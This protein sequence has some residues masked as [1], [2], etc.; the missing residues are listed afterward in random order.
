MFEEMGNAQVPDMADR[1]VPAQRHSAKHVRSMALPIFAYPKWAPTV[2][3]N[4]K[5]GFGAQKEENNTQ[6]AIKDNSCS[7]SQSS[8]KN[9]KG[10]ATRPRHRTSAL[11]RLRSF[12][13]SL[14]SGRNLRREDS[15][16]DE[17]CKSS[18]WRLHVSAA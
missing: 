13:V 5:M 2:P 15:F 1:T 4:P 12:I 10:K 7:R 11:L 14:V 16:Q 8:N 6:Q 3:E 9:G 17:K 18:F